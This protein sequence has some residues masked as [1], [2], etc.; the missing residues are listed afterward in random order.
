M[1][2]VQSEVAYLPVAQGGSPVCVSSASD[3]SA[4]PSQRRR[5]SLRRSWPT[6]CRG[7]QVRGHQKSAEDKPPGSNYLLLLSGLAS[8]LLL[9][10]RAGGQVVLEAPPQLL[11]AAAATDAVMG[12]GVGRHTHHTSHGFTCSE[13]P[14]H[15]KQVKAP[16]GISLCFLC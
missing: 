13:V 1:V 9:L 15:R 3:P 6:L 14:N 10:W 16:P 2:E 4:G 8:R 5:S 11:A 7:Q 12:V